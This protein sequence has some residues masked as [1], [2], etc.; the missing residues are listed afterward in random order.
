MISAEDIEVPA[1]DL[2]VVGGDDWPDPVEACRALADA[3][4]LAV[5]LEGGPT[6]AGAWWR[7]GVVRRGVAYV[8]ARIGGGTGM[9]PLHGV[10][11]SIDQA[12]TVMIS[13]VRRIGQDVRIDFEAD[14]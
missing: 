3:G 5:L 2:I 1:G 14:D 13:E 4:F 11:A 8:G 9:T 12:A 7:A 10:F 6:V